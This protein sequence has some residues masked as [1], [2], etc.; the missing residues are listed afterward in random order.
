MMMRRCALALIPICV[1]LAA[2]APAWANVHVPR[3]TTVNEIRVLGQDVEIDG[4]AKGPVIVIGGTL[5]VGP[6]GEATNVTVIGGSIR[7]ARGGSLRGDVFQ[8]GGAIPDLSGWRLG[9]VVAAALLIRGLLIWALVGAARRIAA[10]RYVCEFADRVGR[11]PGR[12]LAAGA[13]ASLGALALGVLSTLTVVGIP[14]ALMLAGALI[15]GLVAGTAI[16]ARAMPEAHSAR[17]TMVLWLVIP[18]LGDALLALSLALGIGGILGWLGRV[19]SGA[20]DVRPSLT[21]G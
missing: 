19:R 17:G 10:S 12:T 7:T 3:G 4:R 8:F 6:T 18:G 2:A 15:I 14:V 1:A 9:A 5:T 21:R 11:A 13:L 16:V 20:S